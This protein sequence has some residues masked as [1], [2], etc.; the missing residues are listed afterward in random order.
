MAGRRLALQWHETAEELLARHR[1][2]RNLHLARRLQA[3]YLLRQGWR[4]G[5]TA[6]VVVA[7]TRSVGKWL[8]GYRQGGLAE[9]LG[10]Q[11]GGPRPC[12]G[13]RDP[14]QLA[15]LRERAAAVGFR[16]VQEAVEWAAQALGVKLSLHQMGRL[17]QRLG[18]RRRVLRP[19]AGGPRR[20][21][22]GKGASAGDA[23]RG[24][25]GGPGGG[26]GGRDRSGAPGPDEAAVAAPPA[27]AEAGAE[28]CLAVSGPGAG[29]PPGSASGGSGWRGGGKTPSWRR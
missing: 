2:A 24:A 4:S 14:Q 9:L 21:C 16:T 5:E 29:P 23:G 11:R 19:L 25:E 27:S 13:A 12:W 22:A 20:R 26:L 6:A 8:A 28:A 10:H 3:L 7:S 18:L 17:F 1:A 15:S